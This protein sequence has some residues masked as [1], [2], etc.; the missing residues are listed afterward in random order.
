MALGCEKALFLLWPA[1]GASCARAAFEGNFHVYKE[2]WVSPVYRRGRAPPRI[3]V[4]RAE[5]NPALAD[6]YVGVFLSDFCFGRDF[7]TARLGC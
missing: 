1:D 7:L 2:C 6:Q 5:Q 4:D 3:D